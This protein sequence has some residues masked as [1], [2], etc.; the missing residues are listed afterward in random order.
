VPEDYIRKQTLTN[1]ERFITPD[2]K[3]YEEKVLGAE[4]K[5]CTLEYDLFEEIRKQVASQTER[6]QKTAH[7]L[8]QLDVFSSW[9]ELAVDYNYLKPQIEEG[10]ELL[11]REGRHPVLEQR[12]DRFVP[13]DITMDLEKNRLMIITGPNMAGKSTYLRQTALIVLLAQ[14]GCYVPAS[15][16]RI[17]VVDRIFTRV[18]ASDNLVRG[19]ST[20]MVE[21]TETANIL[22]NATA[23]SLIILDEIGRGTSTYDGLSIAWAVAEFLNDP[24]HIGAKTLFA[25]HYHELTDLALEM[26]GVQNHNISVREY[27]DEIIFLYQINPGGADRSYGIEV[28]RLAG[29]PHAVINRAKEILTN[30][31]KNEL[32]EKGEPSFATSKIRKKEEKP[33][34]Q[35]SLFAIPKPNPTLDELKKLD[36]N[37]LTPI[38]ALAK[39]AEIQKKLKEEEE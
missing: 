34:Q 3:S 14:I 17:G 6:L 27:N 18:G 22:N 21:M 2:L 24:Q 8:A 26:D 23:R 25:T 37:N 19:Q 28:A 38:Q 33:F 32:N 1:A 5:L 20:F 16:A 11:I 4:E 30:L 15:E 7:H 31:E 35:L 13:N 29:L 36:I 12:T 39:L 9:G 10:T